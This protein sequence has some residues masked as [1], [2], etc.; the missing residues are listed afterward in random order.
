MMATTHAIV[1]ATIAKAIPDPVVAAGLILTSHY[2]MDLVPHWD[3]GT[4]WKGRSVAQTGMLAGIDTI[5]AFLVTFL[6]F[7]S[8]LPALTI[9]LAICVANLPDWAEAPYFIFF[10]SKDGHEK[11]RGGKFGLWLGKVFGWQ[12]KYVHTKTTF[13][14]GVITQ[15]VTV[16]FF[17]V[18]L[19]R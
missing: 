3:F 18:L 10:A 9:F 19:K 16:V 13:T 11:A 7:W 6:L 12:E 4:D 14:Q 17:L 2:L 8:Q 15:I 1:G 5:A